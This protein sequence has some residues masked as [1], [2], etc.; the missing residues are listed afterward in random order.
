MFQQYGTPQKMIKLK[1][2]E[3]E[4][5]I[6]SIG[7]YHTKSKNILAMTQML[8]E[9]YNG[10]I[11][12][13]L[14]GLTKLP[15]VGRKTA[16]VI[17]AVV[18]NIPALAVDTHVFRVANRLGLADAKTPEKTEMQL[19]ENI[20]KEKWSEA[21]HW[22]IWHGRK[23]CYSRSPQCQLCFLTEN[24]LYFKNAI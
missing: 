19:M 11:P 8:L 1:Q 17:L 12:N 15:G 16:N 2:Q 3:L 6:K 4:E 14:E 18:F 5:L 7:L 13:T 21:H 9:H 10:D 23:I 20:P 22:L 24:C